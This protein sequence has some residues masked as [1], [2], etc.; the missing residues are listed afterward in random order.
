M[1]LLALA[2][3]HQPGLNLLAHQSN[4]LIDLTTY[5]LTNILTYHRSKVPTYQFLATHQEHTGYSSNGVRS[6]QLEV[7]APSGLGVIK[8]PVSA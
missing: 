4:Q 2:A 7:R 8:Q 5:Q 3:K 6:A 1:D